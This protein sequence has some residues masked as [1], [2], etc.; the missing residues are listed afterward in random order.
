M[1]IVIG[2]SSS[3][4]QRLKNLWKI[5]V[6]SVMQRL[7]VVLSSGL[8]PQK[9]ALTLCIGT[10]L[11]ILPLV[12]GTSLICFTLAHRFKLNHV[13]LQSVN[14]L[15]YP[16]QLAL[17]VPFF[18]LGTWLFPYGPPMPPSLLATMAQHPGS[19]LSILVWITFKSLAAWLVTVLPLSFLAYWILRTVALR[20][21]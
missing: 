16:I 18:K 11:G 4:S 8:T 2:F 7:R 14:Y 9:L 12:W 5:I 10:A 20:N 13:A 21:Y 15:L 17:L 1:C 3:A 6:Y 19:S